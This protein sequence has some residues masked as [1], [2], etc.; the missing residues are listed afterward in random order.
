MIKYTVLVLIL[1]LL[2]IS[3]F[4]SLFLLVQNS[5]L[6]CDLHTR[7]KQLNLQQTRK[8]NS[9]VYM[10]SLEKDYERR[11]NVYKYVTP[12]YR[13]GIDGK[14]LNKEE[15]TAKDIIQNQE[16]KLG[17]YGCYLSHCTVLKHI[18]ESNNK[19]PISLVIEDDIQCSFEEVNQVIENVKLL[20]K[21]SWD[22]IFIGH[23]YYETMK[24]KK[25]DSIRLVKT[26]K[27]WGMHGY[28]VNNANAYKYEK[29]FP[30][31]GPI[32]IILP[33]A[34]NAYLIEPKV[35]HLDSKF[36][37]TSNTQGIN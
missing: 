34:L 2:Y 7:V 15:L 16:L 29:L 8:I 23:N 30:I 22:V 1:L 14:N 36:C 31:T 13:V 32:D 9:P 11:N 12:D 19:N 3:V 5:D 20:D 10:I 6:Q 33:S 35:I 28:L 21:N 27:V 37:S 17:E 4:L 24:P 25:D 18:S 26:S